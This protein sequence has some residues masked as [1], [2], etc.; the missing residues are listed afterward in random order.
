M[1]PQEAEGFLATL[2][3]ELGTAVEGFAAGRAAHPQFSDGEFLHLFGD[4]LLTALNTGNANPHQ[5][6]LSLPI[7]L[8]RIAELQAELADAKQTLLELKPERPTEYRLITWDWQE[9]PDF[10]AISSAFT[11]L[12][13]GGTTYGYNVE[14]TGSDQ[15]AVI[16]ST[17]PLD[18]TGVQSVFE[19]LRPRQDDNEPIDLDDLKARAEL[20]APGVTDQVHH[21]LGCTWGRS[22]AVEGHPKDPCEAKADQIVVLYTDGGAFDVKLCKPHAEIVEAETTPHT[23]APAVANG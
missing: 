19:E 3:A 15:Y 17:V 21:L 18:K 7:A 14:E 16:I 5:V 13:R 23:D 6:V 11:E 4:Q 2:Q 9:N 20:V 10:P 22:I 8:H 1:T 12:S